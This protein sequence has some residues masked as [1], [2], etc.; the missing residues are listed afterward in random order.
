MI[1]PTSAEN[2]TQYQTKGNNK[3]QPGLPLEHYTINEWFYIYME[4]KIMF[5]QQRMFGTSQ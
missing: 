3:E 2:N 5:N 1:H 4:P